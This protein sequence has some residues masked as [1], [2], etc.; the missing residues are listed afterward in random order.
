[1]F[2]MSTDSLHHIE[3]RWDQ[4]C[5]DQFD[6]NVK[7]DT[8]LQ[9]VEL[10]RLQVAAY[11]AHSRY[12]EALSGTC[13]G[14]D[15]HASQRS[16]IRD[17][18]MQRDALL[19][20]LHDCTEYTDGPP[21]KQRGAGAKARRQARDGQARLPDG[22]AHPPQEISSTVLGYS[23]AARKHALATDDDN[24]AD[25]CDTLEA[26]TSATKRTRRENQMFVVKVTSSSRAIG[27]ATSSSNARPHQLSTGHGGN[28]NQ[29]KSSHCSIPGTIRARSGAACLNCRRRKTKCDLAKPSC[30]ACLRQR[31]G[32]GLCCEIAHLPMWSNPHESDR[33]QA[34]HLNWVTRLEAREECFEQDSG[35]WPSF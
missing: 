35:T 19:D 6:P 5:L 34:T 14:V 15:D 4:H 22:V 29:S 1:M 25:Q 16:A 11:H 26:Q 23:L 7:S 27:T 20:Q 2:A 12:Y 24:G 32:T 13:Q 30:G 33:S 21:T 28:S 10:V 3:P 18:K 31:K 9:N 8:T 17:A